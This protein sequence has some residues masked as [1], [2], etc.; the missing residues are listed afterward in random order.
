MLGSD[1]GEYGFSTPLAT[2][3]KFNGWADKFLGTPAVGLQDLY[4]TASAKVGP[5]K[6]AATFHKF[7]S[8]FESTDLGS[9]LDLVYAMKF[10]KN[11]N[12]GVKGAFY[13]QGDDN[14]PTD[15]NKI[16]VWFGTKF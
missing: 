4:F 13:T 3:H 7:D 9:E 15:T 14:T 10:G 5:G 12:A 6:L 1:D 16:W 8:D 11:Y 2:L